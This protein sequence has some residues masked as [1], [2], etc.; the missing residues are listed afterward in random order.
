MKNKSTWMFLK[1]NFTYS[2]VSSSGGDGEDA[3]ATSAV[4]G[5]GVS[6]M[7]MSPYRAAA[8]SCDVFVFYPQAFKQHL[9][10]LLKQ[11][12][13]Y[14]HLHQY[15]LAA[16]SK[17]QISAKIPFHGAAPYLKNPTYRSFRVRRFCLHHVQAPSSHPAMSLLA[18]LRSV[19]HNQQE[20]GCELV[21]GTGLR[22]GDVQVAQSVP[23]RVQGRSHQRAHA[24]EYHS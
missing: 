3:A 2:G 19:F 8:V 1:E 21:R 6:C 23:C 4:V 10:K 15:L 24:T 7:F 12:S 16:L 17:P 20:S 22:L 14:S 5:G 11:L 9:M 18:S 13:D